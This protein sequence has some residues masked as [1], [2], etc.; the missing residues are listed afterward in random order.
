M[1]LM[2]AG[3]RMSCEEAKNNLWFKHD[4]DK[5]NDVHDE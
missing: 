4:L 2:P 3:E 5:L 1:L